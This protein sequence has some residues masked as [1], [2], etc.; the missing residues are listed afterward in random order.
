M[1]SKVRTMFN[2][3]L[4]NIFTLLSSSP[5]ANKFSFSGQTSIQHVTPISNPYENIE[6][7]SYAGIK[8][9][10]FFDSSRTV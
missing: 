5:E 2:S 9:K 1:P 7:G 3:R 8:P 6:E 4:S 10:T